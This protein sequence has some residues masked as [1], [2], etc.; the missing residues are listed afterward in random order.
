M[1]RG[2]SRLTA[3]PSRS[4]VSRTIPEGSRYSVSRGIALVVVPCSARKF[5]IPAGHARAVSLPKGR[6]SA[7]EIAWLRIASSLTPLVAA[8]DLYLG[9]G[10]STAARE[11]EGS[12]S[13][14]LVISAGLGLVNSTRRVPTYGLTLAGTSG[15]D[16]IRMRVD[17]SFD[18]A[19][20]WRAVQTGPFATPLEQ[21]FPP[22]GL[23]VM[24]LSQPYARLV[25]DE[26][27]AL[28]EARL[29]RLRIVGAGLL[30]LLP[31]RVTQA[32]LLPYDE[33]LN[34][35]VPGVRAEFAHRALRHFLDLIRAEET[36]AK[37]AGIAAHRALV[38]AALGESS[39]SAPQRPR[40][41]DEAIAV[42]IAERVQAGSR[43]PGIAALLRTL[44]HEDGIA[45]EA[46]RFA[47]IYRQ[48]AG[49]T[50]R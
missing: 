32:S 30:P 24:A 6:Q 5:I 48:V 9:R 36:P 25:A 28:D 3:R 43:W 8:R 11:A 15:P 46:S 16:A 27:A 17:G 20:W 31:E 12:G 34:H 21:A 42:R 19:S 33:R 14:L 35:V 44:R 26:V 50:T 38:N 10:F 49:A 22:E 7:L 4:A 2:V 47:R 29:S 40:V 23:A 41:T 39:P 13:E 45:C 37:Y 1:S 18:P